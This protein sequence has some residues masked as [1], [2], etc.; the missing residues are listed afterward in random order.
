MV[1]AAAPL[2]A[3]C[4]RGCRARTCSKNRRSVTRWP[5]EHALDRYPMFIVHC[6][7]WASARVPHEP[8]AVRSSADRP[9]DPQPQRSTSPST[10]SRLP[11]MPTTSAMVWPRH[12]C[13]SAVRLMKLGLRTW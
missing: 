8:S 11:R 4:P 1:A 9:P 7:I 12:I 2:E 10:M 13:S 6:Q 3:P 5:D